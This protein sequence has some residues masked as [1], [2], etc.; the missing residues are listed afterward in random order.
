MYK[1]HSAFMPLLFIPGVVYRTGVYL[2]NRAFDVGCLPARGLAWPT[3]SVGNLALGGTG[4]TPFVIYLAGLLANMGH[5]TAILTRGYGR[6]GS[7][8]TI[9]LPPGENMDPDAS[10]I[11]DEPSLVRRRLR[12]TWVGIS[13]DRFSAAD[14]IA[15]QSLCLINEKKIPIFILDDGFQRRAV[16]RDLDIVVIDQ[17]QP[18][19]DDRLFPMGALREPI[20]EIRRAHVVV[21]NGSDPDDA[22]DAGSVCYEAARESLSKYA[23]DA[24]FFQC[25]RRIQAVL[26][27]SDWKQ[28]LQSTSQMLALPGTAFLVA[29]IGNPD[30]FSRDIISLGIETRGCAFFKDHSII[31]NKNWDACVNAAKKA[32]AEAVII[33]EKDAVKISNVPD[34]PLLVAVQS[35]VIKDENRFCE[36]LQRCIRAYR[37]NGVSDG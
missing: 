8:K 28:E 9:V 6:F 34:F 23:T 26:S 22:G 19:S 25:T 33:T 35:V 1:P 15:S 27:F 24:E 18:P 32:K 13:S 7:E 5:D 21:V 3:V 37:N 20:T 2:R 31:S 36:I 30:R 4:K 10:R 16:R 11:G 29:A 14:A 17:M 12:Q